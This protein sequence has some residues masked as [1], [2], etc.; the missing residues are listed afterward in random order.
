MTAEPTLRRRLSTQARAVRTRIAAWVVVLTGLALLGA[1][2][3]AY[4]VEA[5][6]VQTRINE[7][8]DQELREFNKLQAE[9]IDPATGRPFNS[10]RRLLR[11]ALSRQVPDDSE[12]IVAF[13][14]G[15]PAL[16]AAGARPE[17]VDFE[18]DTRFVQAVNNLLPQ[19]GSQRLETG[20]GDVVMAVKPV[21]D[22]TTLGAYVPVYFPGTER[23]E[24]EAVLGTYAFVAGI[25]LLAVTAGSWLVAG[26]LLQPVRHLRSTAQEISETDLSRRIETTGND[27]LTDLGNTFNAMLDRLEQSFEQQRRFLDDAGHE[28][29]TPIT[30]VRGN[31]ELLDP[32]SRTDATTTRDLVLDEVDRMARLVDDLMV[33]AKA[34][35]PDFVQPVE[36]DIGILTDDVL[37]KVRALGDRGWKLDERGEG[38]VYADPQR[39]TQALLQLAKNAVQHTYP[40]DV[41]AIGSASGPGGACWWV[42]DTGP[43]VTHA[44]ADRIFERFQRGHH[45]RGSEGSGLGLSIV[46]AIAQAHG[47]EVY[48]DSIPGE[49]A[50]FT[51]VIPPTERADHAEA[52]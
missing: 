47:G 46:R 16:I 1:G 20:Y 41:I 22:A 38:T 19:G 12:T 39:V 18:R 48:L 40:G 8:L 5:D 42:R 4:V 30:I 37:D 21:N 33:L 3:A 52:V 9:G 32:E 10:A 50:T 7:A 2:L 24:Y 26:R 44:D 14:E 34:E 43:G 25:A 29:R 45:A 36:T 31:L 28:L 15:Q 13:V 27:D 6:R 49:G 11:V 51:L 17:Y 23:E 35:R